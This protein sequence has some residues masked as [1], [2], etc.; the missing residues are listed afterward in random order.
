MIT[1]FCLTILYAAENLGVFFN[2]DSNGNT[3][4]KLVVPSNNYEFSGVTL[5]DTTVELEAAERSNLFAN[6]MSKCLFDISNT[7]AS[8]SNFDLPIASETKVAI[9]RSD[10]V[11]TVS[12]SELYFTTLTVPFVAEDADII[13]DGITIR[14]DFAVPELVEA[15]SPVALIRVIN[16]DLSNFDILGDS[17][18]LGRSPAIR[19]VHNTKFTAVEST[20]SENVP[21]LFSCTEES[22]S[23]LNNVE[24]F[25]CTNTFYGGIVAGLFG[26]KYFRVHNSK[27]SSETRTANAYHWNICIG[28]KAEFTDTE[29]SEQPLLGVT[30]TGTSIFSMTKV[31][32]LKGCKFLNQKSLF[33]GG[34]VVVVNA[35]Q[36]SSLT[37]TSCKFINCSAGGAGGA[38]VA[39]VASVKLQF[40]RFENCKGSFVG[41]VY[42]GCT[43]I[44]SGHSVTISSCKFLK[45]TTAG[46][47]GGLSITTIAENPV[48]IDDATT[49]D[50]CEAAVFAGLFA[51]SPTIKLNGVRFKACKSLGAYAAGYVIG[52]D[53]SIKNILVQNCESVISPVGLGAFFVRSAAEEAKKLSYEV[54]AIFVEVKSGL[55]D[56]LEQLHIMVNDIAEV[57]EPSVDKIKKIVSETKDN[58][59]AIGTKMTKSN[60]NNEVYLLPNAAPSSPTVPEPQAK[61]GEFADKSSKYAK[62]SKSDPRKDKGIKDAEAA[63]SIRG[64]SVSLIAFLTFFFLW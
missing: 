37:I 63:L 3:P 55:K 11:M 60:T 29:F 1:V 25:N 33:A 12:N 31:T 43:T 14:S 13:L 40:V 49:F 21:N 28:E 17:T 20:F 42:L 62:Q 41:A 27:F 35:L 56:T 39:L 15:T 47:A 51:T 53:G 34:S 58:I 19:E 59:I 2:I 4:S 30:A 8:I 44:G 52:Y 16:S 38:L 5:H 57:I 48:L 22:S 32:T 9:A 36:D 24:T 46:A 61:E 10:S 6:A 23:L 64:L 45:C 54:E 7:T 50:Q 26:D 18:L